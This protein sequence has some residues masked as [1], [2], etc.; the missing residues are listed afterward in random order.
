[1]CNFNIFLSKF[2]CHGNSLC[3]L[4]NSDSILQFADPESEKHTIHMTKFLDFL[5]TTETSAILA[6]FWLNC[7]SMATPFA[8]LKIY[9]NLVAMA[10]ALDPLK[11][12]IAYLNSPTPKTLPYTQQFYHILYKTKICAIWLIFV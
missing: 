5:H 1:M 7:V 2:G 9:L 11:F 10:T 3:S 8:P 4:E 6:N 12:P